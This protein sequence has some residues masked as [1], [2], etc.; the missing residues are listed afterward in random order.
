MGIQRFSFPD[1]DPPQYP[2]FAEP[3][4]YSAA[5]EGRYRLAEQIEELR[6][7]IHAVVQSIPR[8]VT[9]DD[10]TLRHYMRLVNLCMDLIGVQH[11]LLLVYVDL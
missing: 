7:R 5:F 1:D 6:D 2:D 3:T 8:P 9:A 10:A 4:P 11:E